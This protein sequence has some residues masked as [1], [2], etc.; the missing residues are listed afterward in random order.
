MQKRA[1]SLLLCLPLATACKPEP[2]PPA[3]CGDGVVA[4]VEECD[5][6]NL[7]PGDACLSNCENPPIEDAFL[8][9]EVEFRF[10]IA[11]YC[12]AMVTRHAVVRQKDL[13]DGNLRW[14]CGDVTGLEVDNLGQEYCEYSAVFNGGA[15][16][17]V[18]AIPEG[19]SFSCLFTSVFN[20]TVGRDQELLDAL[21]LQ[22]NLGAF[23]SDPGLVRMERGVNAR[24][25]AVGLIGGAD[26][27]FQ[28][29]CEGLAENLNDIRQVACAEAFSAAE[30]AGDTARA[31]Q[32]VSI[33]RGQ[34][35]T[36]NARFAQAEALGAAVLAEGDAGFEEQRF[37]IG[38]VATQRGGGAFFRNSD[39]QIC[40]RVFRASNECGCSFNAVPDALDG[41]LFSVWFTPENDKFPAECRFAKVGGEDYPQLMICDVPDAEIAQIRGSAKYQADLTSFCDDRFGKNIGI[42]APLEALNNGSCNANASDF[43]EDFV[44]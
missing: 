12:E 27:G 39:T 15:V 24:N 26:F 16:T 40:G 44:N 5:D 7:L 36:D 28:G 25:A 20:D 29:S 14:R 18:A 22:E 17:D 23:V 37:E 2:E 13:E 43:C 3:I 30:A 38:C 41:F 34:D 11:R 4:G 8:F 35:L 9:S 42:L 6:G 31:D 10:D 19:S 21:A 32:L 33:C 1:V